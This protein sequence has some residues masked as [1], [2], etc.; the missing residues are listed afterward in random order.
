MADDNDDL[1]GVKK[2]TLGNLFKELYSDAIE[3]VIY[4]QVYFKKKR[5]Q[6]KSE[7]SFN[8]SIKELLNEDSDD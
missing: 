6:Q 3:D 8:I 4:G 2:D 7:R 5:L 1:L